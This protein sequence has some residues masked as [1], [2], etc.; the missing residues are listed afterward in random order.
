M[1]RQYSRLEKALIA[2][3]PAFVIASG[4]LLAFHSPSQREISLL[5]KEANKLKMKMQTMD[6]QSVNNQ[7]A[8]M[9]EKKHALKEKLN[10]HK[11]LQS[12][13]VSRN[14]QLSETGDMAPA[15]SIASLLGQLKSHG[16]E[17]TSVVPVTSGST[18]H[19]DRNFAE[20]TSAINLDARELPRLAINVH[21]SFLE[22]KSALCGLNPSVLS[23]RIE[24]VSMTEA[25]SLPGMHS[26]ENFTHS[27]EA[28]NS[29]QVSTEVTEQS[30]PAG[31][32]SRFDCSHHWTITVSLPE[33]DR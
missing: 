15:S 30:R 28:F 2:F 21:G 11:Q 18:L 17:C 8:S 22:M 1:T 3:G 4:Y 6:L 12:R 16:I 5:S 13:L 14:Q 9:N 27:A 7:R 32:L 33:S 25:S 23:T 19:A 26:R 24:S 31:R 10:E 20:G 29:P